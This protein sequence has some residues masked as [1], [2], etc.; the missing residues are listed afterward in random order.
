MTAMIS[1][2]P[3]DDKS[4]LCGDSPGASLT[5]R[6][7]F[8]RCEEEIMKIRDR[9]RI[10][11]R[12]LPQQPALAWNAGGSARS[13]L[14]PRQRHPATPVQTAEAPSDDLRPSK[15]SRADFQGK[16]PGRTAGLFS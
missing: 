7:Q 16:S 6:E 15:A 5:A 8:G 11:D 14:R 4:G 10:C 1:F 12:R 9:L 3:R 2:D 13:L